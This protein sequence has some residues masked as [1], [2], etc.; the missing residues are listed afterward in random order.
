LI[1]RENVNIKKNGEF[2]TLLIAGGT[3][4]ENSGKYILRGEFNEMINEIS[5]DFTSN[6]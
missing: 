3:G 1:W 6:E 2:S 4:W 5:F